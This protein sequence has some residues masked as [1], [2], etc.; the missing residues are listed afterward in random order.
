MNI[1]LDSADG[2]TRS[3]VFFLLIWR[4]K[5]LKYM[6]RKI[7]CLASVKDNNF[8]NYKRL[9]FRHIQESFVTTCLEKLCKYRFVKNIANILIYSVNLCLLN[10]WIL[11][12]SM[13]SLYSSLFPSISMFSSSLTTFLAFLSHIHCFFPSKNI[14]ILNDPHTMFIQSFF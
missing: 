8:I 12:L 1:N 13:P 4:S 7:S 11:E 6:F 10:F 2:Y 14:Y 9:W 3:N 5:F